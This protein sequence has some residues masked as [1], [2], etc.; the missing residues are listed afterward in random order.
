MCGANRTQAMTYLDALA[1]AMGMPR[2]V[3]SRYWKDLATLGN[4]DLIVNATSAA[5]AKESLHLPFKLAYRNTLAVDLGYG[6][7]AID[8]LAW[9]RTAGCQDAID[10]LG[11]LVEQA[12]ESFEIWHGVRPQT[13]PVYAMLRGEMLV[14]AT[15]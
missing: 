6:D 3:H 8:L 14:E 15:D 7:A 11:M 1:E 12:A 5:R 4:F 13:D 10:G 9:A 2:R